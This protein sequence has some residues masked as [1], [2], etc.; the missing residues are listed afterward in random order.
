[1]A[2]YRETPKC[3]FCGEI[4]AKAVMKT[5]MPFQEPI[6]GNNFSHWEFEKHECNWKNDFIKN[7]PAILSNEIIDLLNKNK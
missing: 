7:N 4:I 5:L 6:F 2:V 3:P 1:M